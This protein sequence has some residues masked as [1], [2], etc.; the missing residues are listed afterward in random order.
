[1]NDGVAMLIE[2]MK[3]NPEEF[4]EGKWNAL[5]QSHKMFLNP[6][7]C[8]ALDDGV[9]TLMQQRFTEKV[10]EELVDPKSKDGV[11]LNNISHP[12][13][14]I[15]AIRTQPLSL[16]TNAVTGTIS[17]GG[18]WGHNMLINKLFME[19]YEARSASSISL[20]H[21]EHMKAHIEALKRE[22]EKQKEHKTLFGK[23]FNYL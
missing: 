1:M 10:M 16:N 14:T 15:G 7:D 11:T 13:A 17:N 23:L 8:K 12:N 9:N 20:E 5:I 22:V 6:E 3:T 4:T 19:F 21:D 2:R 18:S